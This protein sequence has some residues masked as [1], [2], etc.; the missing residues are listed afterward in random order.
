MSGQPNGSS[1]EDEHTPAAVQ[2]LQDV[3]KRTAGVGDGWVLERCDRQGQTVLVAYVV[4]DHPVSHADLLDRLRG[5]CADLPVPLHLVRMSALPRQAGGEID[6]D[7]LLDVPVI[8]AGVLR[9]SEDSARRAGAAAVEARVVDAP[10]PRI[11]GLLDL[12]SPVGAASPGGALTDPGPALVRAPDLPGESGAPLTLTDALR[13]G[14]AGPGHVVLAR[15]EGH[16]TVMSYAD[17]LE[18]ATRV[19]GGL[20]RAGVGAGDPVL[21]QEA[22]HADFL[23]AFW[24]CQLAGA[25]PVPCSAP[26]ALAGGAA[27][28]R[29]EVVWDLLR[30][31]LVIS[32]HA[33]RLPDAMRGVATV[34]T[35]SELAAAPVGQ[36]VPI[37]PDAIAV[38]LLTSGSTGVPKLVTQTHQA[39]LAMV[40]GSVAENHLT[41]DD[42][43]VNWFPLDHVVGLL[44]CHV[45]D[46][47]LGCVQVHA[48]TELVLEEPLR[49]IDLLCD[50]RA[51]TTWAPNFACA[52]VSSR[53][54]EFP[55]RSWDLSALRSII[56]GGE[57][58]VAEQVRHFLAVLAPFGLRDDCMVPMWGMS[59]TCSGVTYAHDHTGAATSVVGAVCVGPPVAGL[60]LR[61]V[62]EDGTVLREGQTGDLEV[63][64]SMVTA[65]YHANEA[66]NHEAFTADGWFRTGDRAQLRDGALT[67]VG[68]SKDIILINGNNITASDVEAVVQRCPG[69]R[70][71]FTAAV[72]HRRDRDATEGLV[73][74]CS[75]RPGHDASFVRGDVRRRVLEQFGVYPRHVI[76]V[77]PEEI[78]K[79]SIGKIQRS[80]LAQQLHGGAFADRIDTPAGTERAAEA[81]TLWLAEPTWTPRGIT[82]G[83]SPAATASVLV[84]APDQDT[85]GRLTALL[86]SHYRRCTAAVLT[87][88]LTDGWPGLGPDTSGSWPADR[89]GPPVLHTRGA[90][91]ELLAREVRSELGHVVLVL[92]SSG[93]GPI[94]V[95]ALLDRQTALASMVVDVARSLSAEHRSPEPMRLS[96]LVPGA[97]AVLDGERPAA[98][99]AP[100]RGLV[101]SLGAELPAL[102][103]RLIDVAPGRERDALPDLTAPAHEVEVA[104]RS[105]LRWVP[106]LAGRR[107]GPVAS[108]TPLFRAG[109]GYVVTGGLGGIGFEVSRYLL[110]LPGVR[111]LVLGR[112]LLPGPDAA[113][114][115]DAEGTDQVS[116]RV[117]GQRLEELRRLGDVRYAAVD[118][119]DEAAVRSAVAEAESVWGATISGAVHLAGE[120]DGR[121]LARLDRRRLR[122]VLGAKVAPAEVLGRL[123]GERGG[124]VLAFS[125]VNALFGG[126]DV[127]GYAA[128]NSYLDA[129]Q[130]RLQAEGIAA[131]VVSW[132]RWR[133]IGMSAAAEDE[134]LVR[135]RGYRVLS[136]QEG[137]Q[138]LNEVSLRPAGHTVVG[139]DPHSPFFLTRVLSEPSGTDR[140]E[141]GCD[142]LP[143]GSQEFAVPDAL[144][145]RVLGRRRS[146]PTVGRAVAGDAATVS[147]VA[148]IW[149]DVLDV[150]DVGR[151]TGFFDMGAQSLHLPRVQHLLEERLAV[152][153]ELADVFQ[154][155]T[156]LALAAHVDRLRGGRAVRAAAGADRPDAA[157]RR[158]AAS[159]FARLR[160]ARGDQE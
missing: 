121:P 77:R 95:P 143:P 123:V 70:E 84:L 135:A 118:A 26:T 39:I 139:L 152:R 22:G 96:V 131:Y 142:R 32:D 79:T 112:H 115:A 56:N 127:T 25:I 18:R 132:S 44:M 28:E 158:A 151:R 24:G 16:R 46:V 93:T 65:G 37:R 108:P 4:P 9:D 15:E 41:A 125:S 64:G 85:A 51:T 105:G 130:L 13:R 120:M 34:L 57:M 45:R 36:V 62:A 8:D 82:P 49:W 72:A 157:D 145:R 67:I 30:H 91:E 144:G 98:E 83:A 23:G 136:A 122:E 138:A 106:V 116:G 11:Q 53:A 119:G 20:Q 103:V 1:P 133:S 94:E 99:L 29:L 2:R 42:V 35:V 61:I 81:S 100:L 113:G 12:R 102:R 140:L 66:A 7:R 109:G 147:A 38:M 19:A 27:G 10:A 58:V 21:L 40:A 155:P 80:L 107:P 104:H 43:S 78:P 86:S 128:A 97:C 154:H 54:A 48:A 156:V 153:I 117:P 110:G 159:G 52:L 126:K 73:V 17:L 5:A 71:S 160:A 87:A 141:V 47:W 114:A 149:A 134:E 111:L 148:G 124:F 101:R 92:P 68:R 33:D 90:W 69:V 14:A 3:L 146:D 59:E 6:T 88:E 63:T 31:P 55:G 75:P 89:T 150:A 60:S 129:W 74:F 76:L 50:H 137:L